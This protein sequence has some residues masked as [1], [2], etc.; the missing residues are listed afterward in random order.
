MS[1]FK[2]NK[3]NHK[4]KLSKI[5]DKKNISI[6]RLVEKQLRK[7]RLSQFSIFQKTTQIEVHPI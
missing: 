1:A 7:W 4:E 6:T 2:A 3:V 5:K